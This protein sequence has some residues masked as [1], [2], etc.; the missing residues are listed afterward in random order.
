MRMRLMRPSPVARHGAAADRAQAGALPFQVLRA[1]F[2]V[3]QHLLDTLGLILRRFLRL[4]L[5]FLFVLILLVLV[6]LVLVLVRVLVLVLIFLLPVLVLPLLL[7]LRSEER[8]A[9][10]ERSPHTRSTA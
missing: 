4:R 6:L 1:R 9:A 10:K 8:R 2:E 5:L 3:L 7:V